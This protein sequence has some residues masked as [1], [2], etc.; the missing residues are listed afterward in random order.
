MHIQQQKHAKN[1]HSKY[2]C[3][4]CDYRCSRKFLWEQHLGTRKH[5]SA[6]QATDCQPENMQNNNLHV[7]EI[8]GREYKQRSGLWVSLIHI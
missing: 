6:T 7:C 2:Y 5:K 4:V 1:M 3:Q 8:C